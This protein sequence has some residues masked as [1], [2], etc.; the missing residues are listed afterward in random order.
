VYSLV[1]RPAVTLEYFTLER[2]DKRYA[3]DGWWGF[4]RKYWG[5]GDPRT[6]RSHL[7]Y[8]EGAFSAG[9][10]VGFATDDNEKCWSSPGIPDP[11]RIVTASSDDDRPGESLDEGVENLN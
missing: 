1:S 11:Q 2:I 10:S 3:S 4:V 6:L 8:S 5:K 7:A 9:R